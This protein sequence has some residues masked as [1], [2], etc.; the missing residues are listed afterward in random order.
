MNNL[1]KTVIAPAPPKAKIQKPKLPLSDM[2][3]AYDYQR[4]DAEVIDYQLW[5]LWTPQAGFVLRGPRPPKLKPGTYSTA[6]GAAY[7]FGRFA[8]HPYPQLLGDALNLPALNLGFSGIGPVFYNYPHNRALIS[9]INRSK[10][11]T[12]SVFSGRSQ[13]NSLF[14]T[15][16]YSQVQYVLANGRVVPADFAYQ[17]LLERAD[18]Q[19]AVKLVAET[20]RL[21]VKE[22]IQLLKKITVPK[23]LLWFSKRSPDYKESYENI[24]KLFSN[25]PHLVNRPM[26]E[27]LRPHCDAYVEHVDAAGLP[28]PLI[29][30]HTQQPAAIVRPRAYQQGKVQ[31]KSST[32]TQNIYYPSPEMHRNVAE[33]LIPVCRNFCE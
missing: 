16:P 1:E 23:V 7:T 17:Q 5:K 13:G 28:Q 25:F 29:N 26:I 11:V 8:P 19:T 21:Y 10:F 30:R 12:I 9:A 18:R 15:E 32:M 27:A 4:R 33:K 14:R 24:F 2:G 22:F 6:L 3:S 31:L 20:R